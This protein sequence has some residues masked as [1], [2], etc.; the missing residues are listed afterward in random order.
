M[1][2]PRLSCPASAGREAGGGAD[3]EPAVTDAAVAAHTAD[4]VRQIAA[5]LG[6]TSY[7]LLVA[8][9]RAMLARY[10]N[11]PVTVA[12]DL[13]TRTAAT[14]DRIGTFVNQLPLSGPID[15]EQPFSAFAGT[16]RSALRELYP[17]RR[18]ALS[19]VVPGVPAGL[20]LAPVSVSYRKVAPVPRWPG[21]LTARVDW[22]RFGHAALETLHIMIVDGVV[23][24]AVTLHHRPSQVAEG[25][26]GRRAPADAAGRRARRSQQVPGRPGAS[27][28]GGAPADRRSLEQHRRRL[29]RL[30]HD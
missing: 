1:P 11:D 6:V 21:S 25:G 19:R 27:H 10:G 13:G 16:T 18:V 24:L 30:N 2:Q 5:D 20:A 9:I 22:N 28:P 17:L 15:G 4:A 14:R 7:E 8:V 3:A 26:G 12:V 29:P 23:G